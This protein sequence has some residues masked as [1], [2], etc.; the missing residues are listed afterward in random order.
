MIWNRAQGMEAILFLLNVF[1]LWGVIVALKDRRRLRELME[2]FNRL[3]VAFHRQRGQLEKLIHQ[4]D[5]A[6][7]KKEDDPQVQQPDLQPETP[8][9]AI[10]ASPA[11]EKTAPSASNDPWT[12][13]QAK[14]PATPANTDRFTFNFERLLKGNGLFWLGALVLAI[15]GIL[16]AN[17]AIEA[18]L[19]SPVIRVTLGALFGVALVAGAEVVHR[20]KAKLNVQTP[21][22]SAAL[23]SGG[24]VT[25]FA[26]TLVAFD[27]YQFIDV[28]VAFFVLAVI[29]LSAI[30][31][32]LR[33]GP[34]LAGIG[35]IGAYLVPVLAETNSTNVMALLLYVGF[36]SLS[37]IWVADYVKQKWLWWLSFSGHFLWF[38]AAVAFGNE[39]YFLS[40]LLF[41]L[42]TLYLYVFA[43]VLGWKLN[44]QMTSALPLKQLLMPRK[45]QVVVVLTL[46]LVALA[47]V[48]TAGEMRVA[49]TCL[50]LAAVAMAVAYRHSAFDSWPFLVL[51]FVLFVIHLMRRSFDYNDI[52]FPFEGKYLL[53]QVAV[54]VMMGFSVLMLKRFQDRPAY[55]LLLVVTPLSLYGVSYATSA[56]AAAQ[57][58]Y[59]LWAFEVLIIAAIAAYA[60]IKTRLNQ[61]QVAY[62]VLSNAMVTLCLTMLLSESVL[63]LALAAQVASMS[64]LSRT[65]EV[66]IPDWIYKVALL[67]VVTRL[68]FAP[69]LPSYADELL[70]GVHWTLVVYPLVLAMLWFA[71]KHNPSQSLQAW[72]TGVMIHVVALLV[73]TETSYLLTGDYPHFDHL[74]YHESVLLSLNWLILAGVYL[75]RMR[76]TQSLRKLYEIAGVLLFIGAGVL[77]LDVSLFRN[78]FLTSQE[79]GAGLLNWTIIQWLLPCVVLYALIR[80]KLLA[81]TMHRFI[82]AVIAL[83]GFLFVNAQIRNLFNEGALL[84]S[85]PMAQAELYTYSIVWLVLSTVT[86][87]LGQRWAHKP[88]LN[89]GFIGLALVILKAFGIDMANLEGLLRALSF[90]GLGLCLVGIGWLFQRIQP[91]TQSPQTAP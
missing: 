70:L 75:W 66:R 19:L 33:F 7:D 35:I 91:K 30:S 59:P 72:F 89:A 17:Y 24:I 60:A 68:T 8:Q 28:H 79:V 47:L 2:K 67:L 86:I 51:A 3:E 27:Y 64:Y 74:S 14:Q 32:A 73:T 88:L 53:V 69:W 48:I 57:F 40:I 82:Y 5:G 15:G 36:V 61:R 80:L 21:Y 37:A 65:Y 6:A 78:P 20:F 56:S 52:L 85:S 55:L 84:W 50:V 62:L 77:Q 26:M 29:A 9:D 38:M 22:I 34:V 16:L 25:C 41:A 23:A 31:L 1:L 90:I 63:T 87:F 18:G 12:Q 11:T 49:Y 44:Q 39:D 71:I 43:G 54:V 45:E 10:I 83:F 58:L 76:L 42:V 13:L 81:V 4:L 46:L